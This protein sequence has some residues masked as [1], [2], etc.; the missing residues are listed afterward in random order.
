MSAFEA[1]S[2]ME[3]AVETDLEE[4][5]RE[6]EADKARKKKEKQ[7]KKKKKKGN[8]TKK[9][10]VVKEIRPLV[11]VENVPAFLPDLRSGSDDHSPNKLR[12]CTSWMVY[13][14]SKKF[15]PN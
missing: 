9:K 1:I 5:K 14:R 6:K 15:G 3:S 10:K 4:T 2:S 13:F 8:K 11:Y 7:E 12:R